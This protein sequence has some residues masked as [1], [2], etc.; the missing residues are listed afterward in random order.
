M[1]WYITMNEP[2]DFQH[3]HTWFLANISHEFKTPLSSLSASLE[4]LVDE[5]DTLTMIERDDLLRSMQISTIG[6]QTLVNNLLESTSMEAGAFAIHPRT[7]EIRSILA[8]AIQIVQPLLDRRGQPLV[9]TMPFELPQVRADPNRLAQVFINLLS[10]ASK[11]SPLHQKIDLGIDLMERHLLI[12]I[13]DRGGGIPEG[14]R[15]NI[16]QHFKRLAVEDTD[17]YGS[18]LGLSVVQ[19]IIDGHGGT[20]SIEDRPGG[21]SIFWI[22]LP[23]HGRTQTR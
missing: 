5:G 6:L 23:I 16:F 18:G 7:V 11:Y 2:P 1:E 21:G 19:A 3:L 15:A 13:A 14:E 4:L 20:I 10:N 8:G 17:Q 22:T 12:A 9:L